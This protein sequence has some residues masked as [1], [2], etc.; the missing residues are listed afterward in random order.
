MQITKRDG[1]LEE[2][3][4]SKIENAVRASFKAEGYNNEEEAIKTILQVV[5]NSTDILFT[6]GEVTVESIQDAVEDA[7]MACGQ[8]KVAKTY[9][10]YRYTHSLRR[11]MNTTDKTIHELLNGE[12][13]Y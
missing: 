6:K 13:E 7:L 3:N 2:F 12:N 10:T 4:F 8:Y 1:S 5:K 9:I 11:E